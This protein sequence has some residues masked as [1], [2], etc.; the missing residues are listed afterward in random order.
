[1]SADF[2]RAKEYLHKTAQQ[3]FAMAYCSLAEIEYLG[4]GQMAKKSKARMLFNEARMAGDV[5]PDIILEALE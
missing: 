2:L 1:M 3:N 4:L 5:W